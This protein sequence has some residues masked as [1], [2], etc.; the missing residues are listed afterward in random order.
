MW[1]KVAYSE[2]RG[3]V[4][5]WGDLASPWTNSWG[6]LRVLAQSLEQRVCGVFALEDQDAWEDISLICAEERM[7]CLIA[8]CS[9]IVNKS[10][11]Y[12]SKLAACEYLT[13]WLVLDSRKGVGEV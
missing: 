8:G 10:H 7:K 9:L 11:E 4:V 3:A 5:R 12:H 1:G 2:M 6:D 13:A